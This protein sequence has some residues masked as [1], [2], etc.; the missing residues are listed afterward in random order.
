MGTRGAAVPLAVLALLVMGV[1][2]AT[3]LLL[4][5]QEM[6]LGVS[7]L[8]LQSALAAA[9]GGMELQLALWDRQSLNALVAG[10]SMPFGGSLP[11]GGWYRGATRRLN[12]SLFLVRSEGFSRDSAARQELALLVRLEPIEITRAAALRTRGDVVVRDLAV[13]DGSDA[14][15]PGWSG[16]G[17][18]GPTVAGVQVPASTVASAGCAGADCVRGSPAVLADSALDSAML[19]TF[20]GVAFDDLRSRATIILS[21]GV[22]A[23]GPSLL[24][25]ACN[26]VD[27]E[28]WGS[29]TD[30]AGPCGGRFPIVWSDG[31]LSLTGGEG[32][33]VLVVDGDLSLGGAVTFHGAIIVRGR[34][35]TAGAGGNIHGGVVAI[36]AAGAQHDIGGST[37]MQYSSCALDRALL[38]SASP[39]RVRSRSWIQLQ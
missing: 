9:E 37:L 5:R 25:G 22:R 31:D 7:T 24:G 28:N 4:G 15:P 30:P 11:A 3:S 8:R 2:T 21:G 32:Q 13:V 36:N 18:P 33:G 39:A 27:P 6:A 23:V 16:C 10:D 34:I 19:S 12:A 14:G 38:A 17:P 1:L 29:P 26:P 20:G 35:V